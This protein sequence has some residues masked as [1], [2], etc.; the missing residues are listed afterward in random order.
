MRLEGLKAKDVQYESTQPGPLT[1]LPH[2][3]PVRHKNRPR[4]IRR[5]SGIKT[6]PGPNS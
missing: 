3:T 2:K 1:L 6:S 4:S 5:G